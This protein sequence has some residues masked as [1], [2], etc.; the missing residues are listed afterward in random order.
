MAMVCQ[1]FQQAFVVL[2]GWV[3]VSMDKRASLGVPPS[4]RR[5]RIFFPPPLQTPFLFASRNALLPVFGIDCRLKMIGHC[6]DEVDRSG[7]GAGESTQG[8]A[9]KYFCRIDN[10]LTE[11]HSEPVLSMVIVNSPVTISRE[12]SGPA[13]RWSFP[14]HACLPYP[15]LRTNGTPLHRYALTDIWGN[16]NQT[17]PVCG[18]RDR[19]DDLRETHDEPNRPSDSPAPARAVSRSPD[20]R[21]KARQF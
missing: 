2:L 5:L 7:H 3:K 14:L 4:V 9:G 18:L 16:T 13:P 6:E 10:V 21:K 8:C 12:A 11:I 1:N 17:C 15:W 20:D 19:P